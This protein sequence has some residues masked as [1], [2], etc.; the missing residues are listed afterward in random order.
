MPGHGTPPAMPEDRARANAPA[1]GEWT[2]LP[3]LVRPVLP[4]LPKRD[5][6][7]VDP[8]DPE[9]GLVDDPWSERSMRLWSAWR[10]D[11]ATGFYSPTEV[12]MAV[13]LAFAYEELVRDPKPALMAEVRRWMDG[14]ALTPKGK[15]DLRVRLDDA[16]PPAATE[17]GAGRDSALSAGSAARARYPQLRPVG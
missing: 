4:P 9:S 14:L 2:D 17:E 8:E 5:Q 12:A 7:P 3:P 6:V 15:V 16:G 11:W 1:R 10:K 13:E